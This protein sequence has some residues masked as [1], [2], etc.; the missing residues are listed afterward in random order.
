[1]QEMALSESRLK[2]PVLFGYDVVHGYRTIFPM[3]L[4]ESCS[5]DLERMRKS[6]AI[7]ADEAS[8][9]GIAWTFAPM[10]DISRDA[11]WGRVMEGAGE[12]PYLG[13]LIAKGPCRGFPRRKRLAFVGRREY[14]LG[15]LQAL[16]R[17]WG[18]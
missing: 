9:S 17:L 14:G 3:P 12:D 6:A 7:A 18:R 11:R 1:M 4:A 13:S 10:V 5:W 8:A 2:I 16:C 15:L